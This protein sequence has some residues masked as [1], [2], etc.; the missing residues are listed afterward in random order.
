MAVIRTATAHWEGSL[1]EGAGRVSFD[2]SG[3][4]TQDVTWASR[5]EDP[6]GRTS[7][8]ELL[9]AAHA[10]CYSMALSHALAEAGTPARFIDTRAEVAFQPGAGITGI[11]LQVSAEVPGL[12]VDEFMIKAE[13]AKNDCPVSQALA[14][15]HI[16]LHAQLVE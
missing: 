7:P 8:E 5:S 13:A 2:S 9:G 6:N 10:T 16:S 14:A 11:I 1:R 15:T 3:I 12:S 4:G